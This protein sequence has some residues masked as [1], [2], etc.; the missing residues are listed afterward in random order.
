MIPQWSEYLKS[1]AGMMLKISYFLLFVTMPLELQNSHNSSNFRVVMYSLPFHTCAFML[2]PLPT[3]QY[4]A[5]QASRIFQSGQV[6]TVPDDYANLRRFSLVGLSHLGEARR[7][8]RSL[9]NFYA[10]ILNSPFVNWSL[11]FSYI[12]L[13]CYWTWYRI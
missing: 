10:D 8:T 7:T 9:E 6:L 1:I 3:R 2:L 13:S 5:P 4:E 11:L 12:H